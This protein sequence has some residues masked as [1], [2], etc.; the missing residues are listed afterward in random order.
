MPDETTACQETWDGVCIETFV[1]VTAREPFQF[2][3]EDD[4]G[5]EQNQ[6]ISGWDMK[7][8]VTE[9]PPESPGT[10]VH[11]FTLANGGIERDDDEATFTLVL[12]EDV[13]SE[14]DAGRYSFRAELYVTGETVPF[15]IPFRGWFLHRRS[16]RS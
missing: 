7:L 10:T 8:I 11:E 3:E 6:D 2:L 14:I 16:G 9:G 13:A 1:G 15:D 5:V 12:D 4:D